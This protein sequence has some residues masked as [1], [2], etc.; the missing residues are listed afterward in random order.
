MVRS[1]MLKYSMQV[2]IGKMDGIFVAY[3][4]TARLFGFQYLPLY[5]TDRYAIA[6]PSSEMDLRLFGSSEMG[7]ASFKLCV[8]L[9]EALI[10]EMTQAFPNEVG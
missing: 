4:N 8:A 6:N 7:E 2:R 1:A 5:A 10:D 9:F 3:H